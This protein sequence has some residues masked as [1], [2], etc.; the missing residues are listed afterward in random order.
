M[1]YKAIEGNSWQLRKMEG[2]DRAEKALR[3]D[4]EFPLPGEGED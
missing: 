2:K 3:A 1:S 4:Y